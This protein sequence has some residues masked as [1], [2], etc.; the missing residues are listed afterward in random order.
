MVSLHV[1]AQ[2]LWPRGRGW[3]E[4]WECSEQPLLISYFPNCPLQHKVQHLW[5]CSSFHFSV[6]YYADSVAWADKSPLQKAGSNSICSPPLSGNL[7]DRLSEFRQIPWYFSSVILTATIS[8]LWSACVTRE[9]QLPELPAC[10]RGINFHGELEM[11]IMCLDPPCKS[12]L[13]PGSHL[14]RAFHKRKERGKGKR[15]RRRRENGRDRGKDRGKIG[16]M[17]CLAW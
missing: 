4:I 9:N 11:Q 16:S 13:A 7:Y 3:V 15:Q 5:E 6:I 12:L 14:H 1:G 17:F 2:C 10:C 8:A